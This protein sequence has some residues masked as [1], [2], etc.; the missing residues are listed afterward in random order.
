MDSDNS[1]AAYGLQVALGNGDTTL[2]ESAA[3]NGKIGN[4]VNSD[5]GVSNNSFAGEVKEESSANSASNGLKVAKVGNG[6]FRPVLFGLIL[7]V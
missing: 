6:D 5:D 2:T 1:E 4:V 3:P 7:M